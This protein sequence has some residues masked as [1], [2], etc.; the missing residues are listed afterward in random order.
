MAPTPNIYEANGRKLYVH[1]AQQAR[2]PSQFWSSITVH[3][4]AHDPVIEEKIRLTIWPDKVEKVE[5]KN[6]ACCIISKERRSYK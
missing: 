4:E 2:Y 3:I 5:L 6:A 1:G